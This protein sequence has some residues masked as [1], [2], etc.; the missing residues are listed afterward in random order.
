[1]L[2]RA[3]HK[4][5]AI[6]PAIF[7]LLFSLLVM[8]LLWPAPTASAANP[9]ELDGRVTDPSGFLSE[10]QYSA[11]E[12]AAADA[13]R[14]GVGI[15]LVAVDD[16][17][18]Y[19]AVSWCDRTG[20][21]S[22]LSGNSVILAVAVEDRDAGWCTA[23]EAGGAVVSDAAIESAFQ[24]ALDVFGQSDPMTGATLSEGFTVFAN[25]LAA[26]V[27]TASYGTGTGSTGSQQSSGWGGFVVLLIVVAGAL[28][29]IVWFS[30]RRKGAPAAAGG[31]AA[32]PEEMKKAISGASQQLLLADEAVRAAEDELEFARAQFGTV[33]SE[34]LEAAVAAARPAVTEGFA[35][36]S[37]MDAAESLAQKA[38]F[39]SQISARLNQVMP[40][41]QQAQQ[42]L[43]DQRNRESTAEQQLASLQQR[44][45][46]VEHRIG[47]AESE[48]SS[49]QAEYGAQ[50]I[51]SM[52]DNPQQAQNLLQEARAAAAAASGKLSGDRAAALQQID[53][54]TYSANAALAQLQ[55]IFGARNTLAQSSQVLTAAIASITSDLDD[56]SRLAPGSAA[57]APLVSQAQAAVSAGQS[58]LRGE[59]D[60]L[61]ALEDLR[62]AEDALDGALAPLRSNFD[63]QQKLTQM[64]QQRIA[65]AQA[66]VDQAATQVNANH[67][68][69]GI[70]QRTHLSNAQGLLDV[71]KKNLENYPET[72]IQQATEAEAAARAALYQ[73]QTASTQSSGFGL[74][75][76]LLWG[77][78]LGGSRGWGGGWGG[79]SGRR[80]GRS[81]GF[82]GFGGFG[83]GSSRGGSGGFGGFG[84]GRSGGFGGGSSRGGS[85]RF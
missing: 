68:R 76:A 83:G 36:Q 63:Q 24:N 23:S 28:G 25:Q 16:F 8:L 52:L 31:R 75:E 81:G 79:S 21:L 48:L 29:L 35:L 6:V 37:Q 77:T 53:I 34:E 69:A 82:G 9:L 51:A 67:S 39:A 17:S 20:E 19:G 47:A 70:E 50:R 46:D 26:S 45:A 11:V 71:A 14:Q 65:G 32:N 58:A 61:Q 18:G 64:A 66:L 78:I 56:V 3:Q 73:T 2:L 40:G 1:M 59:G 10:S 57:F 72:A 30:S 22:R 4:S 33:G 54:G 7:G 13:A 85:G 27:G 12:D 55:A 41:L 42:A 84:G 60:P 44:I 49:L 5:K 80:G 15:Y 43:R 74:G 62:S 38:Q